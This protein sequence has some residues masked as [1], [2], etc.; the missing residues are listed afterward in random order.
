MTPKEQ[1]RQ[2]RVVWFE[3]PASDLDRAVAFYSRILDVELKVELFGPVKMAVFPYPPTAIG[4]CITARGSHQPG[5]GPLIF[6]NADPILDQ[7]LERVAAAGGKVV[8][9][10]VTLPSDMG[11]YAHIADTEGNVVGLHAIS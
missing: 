10:K 8:L 3:I 11:V 7:V 9:P 6:L 1:Q 5:A 4:G 2:S